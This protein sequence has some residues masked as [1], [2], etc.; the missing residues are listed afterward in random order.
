MKGP[1]E[2]SLGFFFFFY[3]M[4]WVVG[5]LRLNKKTKTGGGARCGLGV[6]ICARQVV[7]NK[8]AESGCSPGV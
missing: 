1:L 6:Y 3:R 7:Q 5:P 2:M 8:S 4:G